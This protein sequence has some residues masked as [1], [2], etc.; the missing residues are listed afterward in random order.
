MHD[1]ENRLSE[2][3]DALN[4]E[5]QP[6]M[7]DEDSAELEKLYATVRLVRSLKEPGLP[8]SGYSRQLAE[9]VAAGVSYSIGAE[10]ETKRKTTRSRRPWLFAPG[11][12]I[13]A[14]LLLV[15][16]VAGWAGLFNRDVALAM[17]KAVGQLSN[18]HAIVQMR[19]QNAAGEEW[20][21][22]E[23]ELWSEG[24]KYAIKQNDGTLTINNGEKKWQ[25]R[26]QNKEVAIL[27]S[28]PDPTRDNFDLSSEAKRA[29]SYPHT[30]VGSETIAGRTA[31]KLKI[32]PPGG[33]EYY[34]WVDEETN[35]PV[36]LQTP[37]EN[38]LQT[39]YT[40]V[41]FEPNIQIDPGI[42][43]YQVPAGYQVIQ[44]N[45]GQWVTTVEEASRISKFQPLLPDETP[46]RILAF[47]DRIVLDYGETTVMESVAAGALEPVPNS[48]LGTAAESPLE[49]WW[50]RLRWQQDGIEIQ[51]EG[52]QRLTLA[53]QI[54]KDLAL[55]DEGSDLTSQAQ[56]KVPVD[57]K[58]VQANQQQ[59]D[60]GSSPWQLDP[61]QAALTFA[62]LQVSP[63]GINGEPVLAGADFELVKNSGAESIVAAGSGPIK[64]VYLKR[65]IR[66]DET[67]IWT[68]IGYD[69]R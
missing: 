19:S 37:M 13:A 11:A 60:R 54:A 26:E 67:G 64:Q 16:A 56:V 58:I 57:M 65:L 3:I 52:P 21:V 61:V 45:P 18:Y 44:N 28:L 34:I 43:A 8:D 1:P 20:M 30:V 59:V 66:Q 51:V 35:L 48:A 68:V 42:F 33:L 24:A 53:R 14:G 49:V 47:E 36:Q 15:L 29:R 23:A 40:F 55:P 32:S 50:E 63:Q 7:D 41:S 31:A 9:D 38:A 2:Y 22:R 17:E 62:N 69:P 46:V 12:A 27:P 10:K 6:E 4:A 5:R 25:V 39:T